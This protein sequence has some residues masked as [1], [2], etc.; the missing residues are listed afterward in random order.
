MAD[1]II[2][3]ATP[4][5]SAEA[6]AIWQASRGVPPGGM[7][8]KWLKPLILKHGRR[9]VLV[10]FE[11]YIA[12]RAGKSYCSPADFAANFL[13]HRANYGVVLDEDGSWAPLPDAPEPE[14]PPKRTRKART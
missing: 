10:T 12:E 14:T 3:A 4:S 5:W 13:I 1:E 11:S 7:I 6:C 9:V 8:G 2:V